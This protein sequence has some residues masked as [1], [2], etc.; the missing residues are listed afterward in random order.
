M[1]PTHVYCLYFTGIDTPRAITHNSVLLNFDNFHYLQIYII[2]KTCSKT[3]AK[4]VSK[5]TLV[6]ITMAVTSDK[7]Q[8]VDESKMT[9]NI[10]LID[11]SCISL[12]HVDVAYKNY[13]E[14]G[15]RLCEALSTCGF[16]YLK[17][18]GIPER[19]VEECKAES[20]KFFQLPD[21]IKTKYRY[22]YITFV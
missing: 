8:I 4:Q 1:R 17:N 15:K 19:T 20:K 9:D 16:A 22:D 11:I 13:E 18:H 7:A 21:D 10:P 12:Q 3:G 2:N 5:S 14:L 6:F